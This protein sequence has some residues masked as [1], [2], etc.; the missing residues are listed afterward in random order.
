MLQAKVGMVSVTLTDA[1]HSSARCLMPTRHSFT[2]QLPWFPVLML[3]G[4]PAALSAVEPQAPGDVAGAPDAPGQIEI[5]YDPQASIQVKIDAIEQEVARLHQAGAKAR[6]EV[7]SSQVN[8]AER[9]AVGNERAG[10]P[11]CGGL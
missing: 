6:A 9:R 7:L 5:G 10:S 3:V 8:A 4:L 1:L 11:R 2:M